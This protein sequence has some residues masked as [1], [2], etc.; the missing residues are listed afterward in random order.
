M[1]QG[2]CKHCEFLLY[3]DTVSRYIFCIFALEVYILLVNGYDCFSSHFLEPEKLPKKGDY[4][5]HLIDR[6]GLRAALT[7]RDLLQ[8]IFDADPNK[9]EYEV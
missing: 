5:K 7:D 9:E 8:R 6:E 4:K 2:L 1:D 3:F